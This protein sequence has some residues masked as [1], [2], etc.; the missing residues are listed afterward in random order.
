MKTEKRRKK[1]VRENNEITVNHFI[2]L[3][4]FYV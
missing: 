4:S 2:V 1:T 3:T